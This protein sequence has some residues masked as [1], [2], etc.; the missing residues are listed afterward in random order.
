MLCLPFPV[1]SH[2][3]PKRGA[4]FGKRSEEHTSELQSRLHLVCR[5]LLEKKRG[6]RS[7]PERPR[8]DWVRLR[9]PL[10][11]RSGRTRRTALGIRQV[12]VLLDRQDQG[13][14]TAR[15]ELEAGILLEE[16]VDFDTDF[17]PRP[18]DLFFFKQYAARRDLLSSH[19]PLSPE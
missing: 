8:Q 11:R 13:R 4:K 18:D 9:G 16:R 7:V 1:G 6:P 3:M 19:P 10:T 15:G 2:A 14:V 12:V 17:G 5:L